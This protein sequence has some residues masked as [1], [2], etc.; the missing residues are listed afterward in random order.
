MATALVTYF[1]S[2][3]GND[4]WS[5]TLP[6][7]NASGTDGPWAS[8]AQARDAI[9]ARIAG[10]KS[11]E[12]SVLLRGGD[13]YL[14]APLIFDERD[15]GRDGFT[16]TYRN[17][18]GETPVING[19]AT[20]DGWQALPGG[21]Y[22]VPFD[23]AW[24]FTTLCADGRRCRLARYPSTDYVR[25]AE[26][27]TEDPKRQFR[28]A[29]GDIPELAEPS[30][31]RVYI[32]PGG[33]EGEWNWFSCSV[34]V[35]A[36]DPATRTVTLSHLMP[37]ELGAGSRYYWQNRREF[38]SAPDE[39]FVDRSAS[40]LFYQPGEQFEAS[41]IVVPRVKRIIACVGSSEEM[42]VAN[43]CFEGL[44]LR[45]SDT[46]SGLV[47]LSNAEG[48]TVRGCRIHSA[49]SHGILVHGWAQRNT[50][51]GNHVYD[52]GDT[53]ILVAVAD[54]S[55]RT[56][57]RKNRIT[58]NHVHDTGQIVGHG[59]GI[60]L[61]YS[62]ENL[63]AHNRVHHTSR[64]SISLK[65]RRPGVLIG[66]T[67]EGMVVTRDNAHEFAVTR[68]NIIEFNDL[69]HANTDSQDTGVIEAW[70][71]GRGNII[72][73]NRIHDSDI[74]FSFGFGIYLDDACDD[75]LVTHNLLDRLQLMGA[76]TLGSPLMIKGVRNLVCNNLLVNNRAQMVSTFCEMGEEPNRH[77]RMERNVACDCGDGVYGFTNWDGQPHWDTDRLAVSE[78]NLF[79]NPR[80]IYLLDNVPDAPDF[81]TWQ[82]ILGGKY[83]QQTLLA[84]PLVL[85]AAQGDYRLRHASPAFTLGFEEIDFQGIGLTAE[86]PFADPQD[87]LAALHLLIDGQY[88]WFARLAQG[89]TAT[90]QVTGRTRH[91]YV[92]DLE[93]AVIVFHSETPEI[94]TISEEGE[95]RA[96][97]PGGGRIIVTVSQHAHSLTTRLE[98]VVT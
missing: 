62:G 32:W 6:V 39:F 61:V 14:S 45:N 78:R 87:P 46:G 67:I 73:N 27:V 2:P 8:P 49:G 86:Y 58:N 44:T 38:L 92:A 34:P 56:I 55:R 91:G 59:A 68:N 41:S 60:Q 96:L 72:R 53:G 1:V 83:D 28:Y 43:L 85:D 7:P 57:S 98:V 48:I 42:R 50:L 36:I 70:G 17:Y 30:G 19:G 40:M 75:F 5:G 77:V 65:G 52:I 63:L 15:S 21:A 23:P 11:A 29:P 80:G 82:R 12:I 97:T 33:L 37:Y 47:Y 89:A 20:L 51:T 76:G 95:L 9:R 79:F 64:Y 22:A 81:I 71:V 24:Q 31:L 16:I 90:L 3:S 74:H 54:N 66:E 69:S 35:E 93:E 94:V 18:P 26:M 25:V 13:Y 4:T 88:H 10:G 84:D